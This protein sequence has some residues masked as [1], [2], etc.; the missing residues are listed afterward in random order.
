M[1]SYLKEFADAARAYQSWAV[2]EAGSEFENA[3]EGLR[4]LLTLSH[5]VLN[6][7]PLPEVGDDPEA[8]L[9]VTDD[10]RQIV[11]LAA[12]KI[13]LGYYS[14]IFDPLSVPLQEGVVGDLADDFADIYREVVEGLRLYDAGYH[15]QAHWQWVFGFSSHWGEH[16]TSAIRVLHT[17][18]AKNGHYLSRPGG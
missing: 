15:E 18:M 6:L 7:S 9:R 17:F 8:S 3:K 13:P 12:R 2:N 4:H 5:L 14:E 16:A 11:Y 10:E 1:E